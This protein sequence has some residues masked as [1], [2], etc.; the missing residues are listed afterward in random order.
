M[1]GMTGGRVIFG[2]GGAWLAALAANQAPLKTKHLSLTKPFL[3]STVLPNI[4]F[5]AKRSEA[6]NLKYR[7]MFLPDNSDFFYKDEFKC[8]LPRHS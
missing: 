6:K 4:R 5:R 3:F 8:R 2:K 7:I 1:V